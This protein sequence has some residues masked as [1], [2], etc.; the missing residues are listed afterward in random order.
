MKRSTWKL[1]RDSDLYAD[2]LFWNDIEFKSHLRMHQ[3]TFNYIVKELDNIKTKDTNMRP[4]VPLRKKIMIALWYLGSPIDLRSLSVTFACGK[5]T[6][7]KIVHNVVSG[8]KNMYSKVIRF[9]RTEEEVTHVVHGFNHRGFPQTTGAVDGTHLQILAPS[10][11]PNDYYNRKGFYSIV[12]QAILDHQYRFLDVYIGWPGKAHDARIFKHSSICN[13]LSNYLPQLTTFVNA[14]NVPLHLIGDAAYPLSHFLMTPFK[15]NLNQVQARYN[16]KHSSARMVIE[17][18]FGRLKSRWRKLVKRF[19]GKLPFFVDVVTACCVLNNLIELD[20][21]EVIQEWT[22]TV[23]ID[24]NIGGE[25]AVY[26]AKT[27]RYV[28]A[29]NL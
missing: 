18:T 5:S 20:G 22:R 24:P 19:D 11:N 26:N 14:V 15:G 17:N 2:S 7:W 23:Q 16:Y 25:N 6:A 29:A 4:A 1:D 12:M 9:P 28:I 8:L 27:I 21:Q 10:E 13:R 3:H